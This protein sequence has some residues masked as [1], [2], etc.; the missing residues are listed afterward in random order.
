MLISISKLIKMFQRFIVITG[1]FAL[2]TGKSFCQNI[3]GQLDMAIQKLSADVQFKH[4]VIGLCVT[5][6]KTGILVFATNSELGLAP[7]SCQKVITSV[8]AF[9]LLGKGFRYQTSVGYDGKISNGIIA[10]NVYIT[11]SGDPTLGSDRWKTTTEAEI[12]KA[13]LGC[14]KK[15]SIR[16]I[17]G[18]IVCD[19]TRF[20]NDP[21]PRGWIWED[22]GNYYGAGAWGLNWRE[23]QFDIT[24]KTGKKENDAT[25]IISTKPSAILK[26]YTIANFVTTGP[27]GSGDN[28]YLFSSPFQKNIIARGTVPMQNSGFT[29]SG[30]MPDPPGVFIQRVKSYLQENGI[31]VNGSAWSNSAHELDGK[32]RV[33]AKVILD[34]IASPT[35]DSI[36]YWLLKKS[37]NLFGEALLKTLAYQ[38][39][40]VGATDAGIAVVKDFWSLHGVEKSAIKIIDGS[41]LSPANRVTANSLVTVM[42]YAQSRPWFAS[43]YNAL[44]EANG[45]K[46]K[47]GYINGVRSYTGYV[48]SKS[49]VDYTFALIVNNFDGSAGTAREKMWKVLNVL[50]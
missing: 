25:E 29:I 1:W 30:S 23:N 39:N 22:I 28:G 36:N 42:Q 50:K 17:T 44:P 49:G 9:E 8:A 48:K 33:R 31:E 5:E 7:A 46:M 3:A 37:V 32:I 13:I 10:G 15:N 11:G 27:T 35:L 6:S 19:D 20:T 14:L 18:D 21:L 45:I 38:S 12:L 2:I 16:S 26:D 47:D 41:G 34:S 40:G 4:A 24:F 43:F